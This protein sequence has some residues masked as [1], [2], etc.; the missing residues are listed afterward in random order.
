MMRAFQGL[1]F[2]ALA[3]LACKWEF[4]Q[5]GFHYGKPAVRPLPPLQDWMTL[6]QSA[7]LAVIGIYFLL[8]GEWTY[9]RNQSTRYSGDSFL[10]AG[11]A[12]VAVFSVKFAYAANLRDL[13]DHFPTSY[14]G[15]YPPFNEE[16]LGIT[17]FAL[18]A[19]T[20]YYL[21]RGEV[22][23]WRRRANPTA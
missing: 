6:L 18:C 8:T 9:W 4:V 2:L 21:L 14:T 19:L 13:Y 22:G 17:C 1:L 16:T 23:F 15:Y 5:P 12:F 20:G 3:L 11:A 10:A 7:V